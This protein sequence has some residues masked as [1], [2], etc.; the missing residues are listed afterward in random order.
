MIGESQGFTEKGLR[1]LV[2]NVLWMRGD[3]HGDPANLDYSLV[4]S[5]MRGGPGLKDFLHDVR[6]G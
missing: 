3:K 5:P 1:L 4:D 2:W 6:E